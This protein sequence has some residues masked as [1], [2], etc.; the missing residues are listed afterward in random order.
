MVNCY[1]IYVYIAR[2]IETSYAAYSIYATSYGIQLLGKL[3]YVRCGKNSVSLDNALLA[4][5]PSLQTNA[6]TV[7]QQINAV[8]QNANFTVGN[9]TNGAQN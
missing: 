3:S 9:T 5:D 2:S 4:K 6:P 1:S 7:E 8:N